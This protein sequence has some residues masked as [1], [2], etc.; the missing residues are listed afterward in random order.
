MLS[1]RID[2]MCISLWITY[3]TGCTIVPT[4]LLF[5]IGRQIPSRKNPESKLLAP[6]VE[7]LSNSISLRTYLI[8][9][10]EGIFI[11]GTFSYLGSYISWVYHF[12]YLYIGLIMTAFGLIAIIGGRLSGR[13]A[14]KWGLKTVLALGF[15]SATAADIVFYSI[16]GILPALVLGVT[17]LGFGFILAHS[18]LLTMATEFAAQSRGAAMSLVAFC[19]MGGG[20]IGTAIGGSIIAL[21]D[22]SALFKLYAIGLAILL[23]AAL[24]MVQT[25]TA[26]KTVGEAKKTSWLKTRKEIRLINREPPR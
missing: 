24:L 14:A 12:N 23:I 13:L 18:T 9:L 4:V 3:L 19:L 2:K 22:F 26:V 8:I 20:G 17:L 11:I 10:L 7:L 15:F 6:Y 25:D 5:T 1:T 16:G 21:S